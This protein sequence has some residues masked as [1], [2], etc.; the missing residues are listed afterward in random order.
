MLQSLALR[1]FV[2]VDEL[3]LDFASGFSVLTGETGAGKSILLDALALAL[4][5]RADSSQIREGCQRAEISVIFR[6]ETSLQKDI[7]RWLQEADFP[8]EDGQSIV[9][10][11]SVDQSGRSKAFI[12]GGA[13]SLG[14]LRDLGD[15]LVDIHGQHAHQ[16]L[17]KTGAQRDLLD[18][19]ANLE[20]LA[21]QVAQAYRRMHETARQLQQAEA[22]GADLQREQER[23]QWQ[24]DEFNEIAPQD[25]EWEDLKIEHGRL[26]NAAKII[27]GIELSVAL[28]SESENSIES[29]LNQAEQAIEDLLKHDL[30]LNTIHENLRDA[31]IQIDEAIHALNRYRQK[32]DVDPE[33]LAELEARMQILHDAARKYKVNPEELP[34][35]WLRAQE[36]L[37]AFTAAQD[38][39]SL[40][41]KFQDQESEFIKQASNLSKRRHQ[42]ALE[43]GQA[44]STA[45]QD[46]AMAGGQLEVKISPCEA[47]SH[48]ID[49]VEFLIAAHAGSTPR[50]LAK[51][52]SGGELARISLAISVI[53][54]KASFTPTLIFDEVDSGI[55]GA[56]AQTVGELLKQLGKSHQ[57]LCV[58]HLPQVAAQS[59]HHFKVSK[60]QLQG[61]THSEVHGLARQDRIEE[62]ARMLG[63]TS[64]TETTRRHARE[65]L[66]LA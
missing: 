30:N 26:A 59:D 20:E 22:A 1:D 41:Q 28:L 40:R 3:E 15:R 23:L 37:A 45:M 16:L 25:R 62:I 5:E 12:N 46:L 66:G 10:K 8:L 55:G 29:Q 65:L 9:I 33:R 52:A 4:G 36:K 7:G 51:V 58:T 14:Q 42:A 43:L 50:P 31:Q 19:H 54:S 44:V 38:I 63:G 34:A 17:L 53:T 2:I 39:E 61:K 49:Q 24:V 32:M 21:N 35:L 18:R 56:V 13:A 11:R 64:I 60:T 47:S 6:I 48:G 27:Q 57:I